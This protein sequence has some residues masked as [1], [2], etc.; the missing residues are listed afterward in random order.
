FNPITPENSEPGL[1]NSFNEQQ[2]SNFDW[3][4]TNTARYNKQ[5]GQ[6]TFNL[7]AGQE[8]N[9]TQ[10]RGLFGSEAALKSTDPNNLYLQAALGDASTLSVNSNG[11]QSA[12]LSYFGK[13]DWNFQDKYVANFTVRRDGSSRLGPENRWGTFPSVGLG[14]RITKE[15]FLENN[16]FLSDAM[17]RASYGVTGNQQ[18]PSGRILNQYGGDR[19]DTYYD[20]TGS[21]SSIVPGYRLTALGNPDLKW[22]ENRA[23]NFGADLAL[24]NGYLN[25]IADFY[26]R[27]TN[28][29]LFNPQLPATAGV[30]GVT[31]QPIVNVGKMQ[32]KGF[33][34]SVGHQGDRWNAT[35]Q[36]SHY[37]N[38]I[39]SIDGVQKFFYGP[40]STRYGNQ[41]INKVGQ[42]IG[43]FYGY[44]ADGFFQSD[45]E[46]AASGQSGAKAGRIKFRDVNGDGK[47]TSDD[48]TIIGSPHPKFTS[49]LDLGY[50]Y[51]SFDIS[52][53]VF[54]TF[55]NDIF[56]NQKEWY[57]FREFNTNVRKDLL[58]N[59]WTPTNPNAK[60]PRIDIS[61]T[62]SSSISSFY[63]EDGSYVRMRN[64]QLGYN[65]PS[66]LSR[67]LSATRVYVQA[68]NLFTITGYNGLDP[69]LPKADVSG[70]AGD[71]RDQYMGV[72]RG[73]YPSSRTFSIGL[74]ASF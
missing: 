56:D 26:T 63:V 40:V 72:D 64:I 69:S 15:G 37:K 51:G 74:T 14:W 73:S 12:L 71:I 52:G 55:G 53:T 18:I 59:S 48:R 4:W 17:L 11:N 58:A 2:T 10:Y 70:A 24:F 35:I 22:E 6:H 16:K 5:L 41:V 67:W 62:Y 42:P 44:V 27:R 54:G 49:S 60:Y 57:V 43:A 65:V 1:T 8:A 61:D 29:L 20:I 7:L 13:A 66:T 45:A 25:V 47:I 31:G 21:N 68:E 39:L 50:R 36:G 30:V 19:G 23:T 28:N 34:L 33:D 3:T 9:H 46:A 38:E 32:N